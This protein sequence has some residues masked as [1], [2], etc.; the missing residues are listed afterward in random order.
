MALLRS[1]VFGGTTGYDLDL[2]NF[3]DLKSCEIRCVRHLLDVPEV[4][5]IMKVKLKNSGKLN[6]CRAR[7][8]NLEYPGDFSFLV[9]VNQTELYLTGCMIEQQN[10]TFQGA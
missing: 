4:I 6:S 3:F 1:F 2:S 9:T 5:S 7:F 10:F 8:T